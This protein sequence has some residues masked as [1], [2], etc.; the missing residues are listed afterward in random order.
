MRRIL[1]ATI[2]L[3]LLLAAPAMAADL[4]VKGPPPPIRV[5]SWTGCYVG[6]HGGGLWAQ[7]EWF[8]TEPAFGAIGIGGSYGAHDPKSWIAGAQAGCDYQSAGGFVAGIAGDYDWTD[9]KASNPNLLI[10]GFSDQSRI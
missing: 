2:G 1:A 7:E 5:F 10:P 3:A 6:G 4:A 8:N 9:A